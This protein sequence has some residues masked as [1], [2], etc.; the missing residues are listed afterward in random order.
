MMGRAANSRQT[1]GEV[2]GK[3]GSRACPRGGAAIWGVGEGR[4]SASGVVHDGGS[5]WR[6]HAG[7]RPDKPPGAT[8]EWSV[9]CSASV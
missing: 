3:T 7:S 8:P 1:G 4:G 2:G 6:R 5:W 9:M